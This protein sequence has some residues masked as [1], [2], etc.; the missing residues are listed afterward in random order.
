MNKTLNLGFMLFLS[1]SLFSCKYFNSYDEGTYVSIGD[2]GRKI[3]NEYRVESFTVNG[4]D[5]IQILKRYGMDRYWDFSNDRARDILRANGEFGSASGAGGAG[6]KEEVYFSFRICSAN[7]Q[8]FDM[9]DS[10]KMPAALFNGW[11]HI[12]R[13]RKNQEL[14][15]GR[16]YQGKKY[17]LTL[18]VI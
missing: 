7:G 9:M 17:V 2:P 4:V 18:K 15:V 8:S 13:L 16:D 11:W 10:S 6:D 12:I 5:S 14:K 3:R 1:L